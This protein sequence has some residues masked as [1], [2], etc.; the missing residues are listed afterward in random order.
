MDENLH[1]LR[2]VAIF[3]FQGKVICSIEYPK[4]VVPEIGSCLFSQDGDR[5]TIVGAGWP[6]R[7]ENIW[8]CT[9]SGDIE[10]LKEQMELNL[11]ISN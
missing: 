11:E 8:E 3:P 9:L 5:Y 10:K 4:N 7:G 6:I 1:S 2:V